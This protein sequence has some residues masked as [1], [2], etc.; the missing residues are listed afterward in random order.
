MPFP[1]TRSGLK[2]TFS[3]R[4]SARWQW[5]FPVTALLGVSLVCVLLIPE[6]ANAQGR[7]RNQLG[8][9]FRQLDR[10][11]REGAE[12]LKN[13][14][15]SRDQLDV[16]PIQR[17]EDN[18]RIRQA[19]ELIE[20]GKWNDAVE[21][22]Q[23]LLDQETDA[24]SMDES[25]D[26]HSLQ[27]E[28]DALIAGLP[29]DGLRNYQNRYGV[30]AQQL[31]EQA[32]AAQDE[33]LLLKVSTHYFQ[34]PAGRQALELLARNWQDRGE[35]G[36]AAEAW[37]KLFQTANEAD[38]PALGQAVA[39]ILALSGRTPEALQLV[40]K[41]P[42]AELLK[43]EIER[44]QA[45]ALNLQAASGPYL[46]LTGAETTAG[47]PD[48]GPLPRWSQNLIER[49]SVTS[50]IQSMQ[51]EL[52]EQG[53]ALIPTI[54][55]LAVD[56]KLAFRTLRSLQ[57]RDL[58]SG[59][60]VWERRIPLSAEELMTTGAG[61]EEFD[62]DQYRFSADS[63]VEH[64]PLTSLLY[65]DQVY[66]SLSSDGTR[67]FA[68]EL[69]GAAA[70]SSPIH[71]WQMS[72]VRSNP[73]WETNELTAY[74]LQT[75]LIRWQV[76]GPA[77]EKEF[78]RPLAGTRF[79]GAP[80]PDGPELFVIGERDGEVL[81]FC[82]AAQSGEELW[83]QP[84]ASPGRPI[85]DDVLRGHW[86]CIPTLAD[87]LVLCP[88]TTGWL[89]AV[90]RMNRR[91]K[92]ST[93]FS[94]RLSQQERFRSGY[95]SQPLLELNRRWQAVMTEVSN[96]K[97][98]VTPPE[99]PD[100]FGMT[101]P[102]LSCLDLQ[103]GKTL[104]EQPKAERAGGMGLYLAGVWNNQ[105]VI[106]GTGNV[107]GR[108]LEKGG[109]ISW[110]ISLPNRPTG[111]GLIL[112]NTLF[113]PVTG[114]ALLEINLKSSS[115]ENTLLPAVDGELGNLKFH[116][117]QFICLTY[118]S[119]VVLRA[120]QDS[121]AGEASPERLAQT[122]LRESKL[123]LANEQFSEMEAILEEVLKS[124][125]LSPELRLEVREAQRAGLIQQLASRPESASQ[126]LARL[127]EFSQ[128]PQQVR[129]FQRIQ[130]DYLCASGDAR[131]ALTAYLDILEQF[132]SDE[133]M[134][135]DS[136]QSRVDSWVNGRLQQLFEAHP[137]AEI[138]KDFDEQIQ[139]R[140]Q[141]L[142][143]DSMQR[144]RWARALAFHVSGLQL[145]LDLA[146]QDLQQGAMATGL[147]RLCRVAEAENTELRPQGLLRLAQ[148]L[149]SQG[150]EEDALQVWQ[151]LQ[152]LPGVTLPE[153]SSITDLANAGVQAAQAALASRPVKPSIW[154][155]TWHLER[156]GVSG[157]ERNIDP[158]TTV[159][160]G[161]QT[162]SE[163]RLIHETDESRLRLEDRKS[164]QFL[165]SFPL[166]SNSSLEH[167]S[168]VGSRLLRSL[169]CVVHQGTLH[170]IGW[171]DR[172]ML[173][174]WNSDVHGLALSRL[175]MVQ[176]NVNY[177][178]QSIQQF[179]ATRQFQTSRSQTGYLLAATPRV[180]LVY[181]RDWIAIDPL[182]GEE[183]WRVPGAADRGA[184]QEL[185]ADWVVTSSR[186]GRTILS[187]LS[188]R[189]R[190]RRE[191]NESSIRPI[192]VTG[193]DQILLN[194]NIRHI[195]ESRLHD[196]QR[197]SPSGETVWSQQ[198]PAD[199]LLG[200]P[201]NES[202]CLLSPQMELE[203][204][205]LKTG[206]RSDLG[207]ISDIPLTTA[208]NGGRKTVSILSDRDR[209]YVFVDN[210]DV[211]PVY[212]NLQAIRLSGTILAFSR[213]GKLLWKYETPSPGTPSDAK[214]AANAGRPVGT[215]TAMNVLVQ[216]FEETPLLLLAGVED[217]QEPSVRL[218]YSQVRV[219]GIDKRTGK[220]L[221]DW[222]RPSESGGFTYLFVD[223]EQKAIE[224]RTYNERLQLRPSP[225]TQPPV[226]PAPTAAESSQ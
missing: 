183:L 105:A 180:L 199:S 55:P 164:G 204:I 72:E 157:N 197:V 8:D 88:T 203:L 198:I 75:G 202:L 3:S 26:F 147:L 58:A 24:F 159:G 99:V 120:N 80:T 59:K 54:Y 145:E 163:L 129:D 61:S 70:M 60:L 95:S 200:M 40:E 184:A 128:T 5:H 62:A 224:L 201:D 178:L 12:D 104:W 41:L 223:A 179:A 196:L 78:S 47:N 39:R 166:R 156:A 226:A 225:E 10:G 177:G 19:N 56:G 64:H 150:W 115:V 170:A 195:E 112:N 139:Q 205:D 192:A 21:I 30:S 193:T 127:E 46:Q 215:L 33:S 98:L 52:N 22:L 117:G 6:P 106:V 161:F 49:Y 208:Q 68:V 168:A 114:T 135:E 48:P 153:G 171:P 121:P 9:L 109:E 174:S 185:G 190:S 217:R 162:V 136:L 110:S 133:W 81:L 66:G 194:R 27:S 94:P 87:G 97:V 140:V 155:G 211:R 89:V 36:Q 222:D 154:Q 102:M 118:Q 173:W 45:P 167:N 134:T 188:G 7:R 148:A 132:P 113:L 206:Q 11:I 82:L 141:A 53:R 216:D 85:R 84:L 124:D 146:Q 83:S 213:D 92:W 207:K 42:N 191:S 172:K 15:G 38:Q 137:G 126:I 69:R 77:I 2:G 107:I 31:L 160:Q 220:A 67:L 181:C 186:A 1:Y 108:S 100:E 76:G 165:A 71:I 187:A 151:E 218:H 23:F 35:F 28:V 86:V 57:V 74:D 176:P 143:P 152:Q 63:M 43:Q 158:I 90:D 175:A 73:I 138:R 37:L 122:K 91:L 116:H 20:Q 103:T 96:G 212:I 101:Q 44:I 13:E 119:A 4:Q 25:R 29:A 16:R 214:K 189:S 221:V 210:G 34:T 125:S 93:R 169:V 14:K 182:S 144:D 65:R 130:A 51:S 32:M 219:I 123:L 131:G 79:F 111:R 50:Q 17:S 18:R 142:G 149:S 209:F